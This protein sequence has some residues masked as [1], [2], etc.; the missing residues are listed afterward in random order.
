MLTVC[1]YL[2]DEWADTQIGFPG[3]N[4][5]ANGTNLYGTLKQLYLLKKKNRALK[6]LFSIG[7]WTY[8]PNFVAPLASDSMRLILAQ[9]AV[10]L[11][12]NLGFDGIDVD[13]EY[14]TNSTQAAQVVDLLRLMRAE[15]DAYK[16]KTNATSSFLLATSSP[17]GPQNYEKMDLAGMDT[18]LD[19]WSFMGY[20]YA[21]SWDNVTGHQANLLGAKQNQL[22]VNTNT[23]IDYY[24]ANGVAASKINLGAPLYGR[25][26][27]NTSGLHKPFS[28]VGTEG[29][30]GEAGAWNF[31]HLP[32]GNGTVI[33]DLY[34]GASY[35]YDAAKQYLISYDTP[36]V[37]KM[38]A[39]YVLAKGLG[40]SMW[41]E[42]SQD[43]KGKESLV[44]AAVEVYG[45]LESSENHLD[46]PLSSFE[47]LRKGMP[48]Y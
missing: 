10:K 47:N 16:L 41:W 14:V 32:I 29:S 18:Y 38:K 11:M 23:G 27:A 13:Y 37:A 12:Y 9:S 46:Y 34:V 4:T 5:S 3:D 2:S 15:M 33:E 28:G 22:D 36:A 30:Y 25:A 35:Y 42:M 21:G 1:S 8:S 31:N 43:K 39:L 40:G 6:T 45:R 48:G 17:A 19:F 24:I 44:G 20:D 26:F 7:G